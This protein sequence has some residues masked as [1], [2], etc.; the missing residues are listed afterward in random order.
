[1]L[2]TDGTDFVQIFL[3]HKLVIQLDKELNR[4]KLTF[5]NNVMISFQS[6]VHSQ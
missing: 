1:M 2:N 6:F 3:V 5:K 4:H